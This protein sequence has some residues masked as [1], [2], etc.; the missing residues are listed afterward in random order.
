VERWAESDE[1]NQSQVKGK[2]YYLHGNKV[3][4]AAYEYYNYM[5]DQ[6]P[7]PIVANE[8]ESFKKSYDRMMKAFDDYKQGKI[9]AA[10]AKD[11]LNV[12]YQQYLNSTYI[13][14]ATNRRMLKDLMDSFEE[15][16]Q[17]K[18][19]EKTSV[20]ANPKQEKP[21]ER[22]N[23]Y[24]Q[25]LDKALDEAVEKQDVKIMQQEIQNVADD[26]EKIY[27]EDIKKIA[28][29]ITPDI[30]ATDAWNEFH[31]LS[32][33]MNHRNGMSTDM[34]RDITSTFRA[35]EQRLE[36]ILDDLINSL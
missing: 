5:F 32:N 17:E 8:A 15:A 27:A 35:E 26:I 14:N 28:P 20:P 36:S 30:L 10:V 29:Q 23:G 12:A 22:R 19:E 16:P 33:R 3:G 7:N 21:A 25:R 2:T 18:Q 31:E 4:K 24:I 9:S 6:K 34:R 11:E 13:M 1:A